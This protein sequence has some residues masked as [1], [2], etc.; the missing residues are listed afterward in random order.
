MT[1]T[2]HRLL[3]ITESL[4]CWYDEN[5]RDLPWRH[6]KEPYHIWISEIMAQQT[7]INFLLAYY[8]R[9]ISRFPTVQSLAEAPQDEVLK[10]W[11]GLGYYSR[12]K[13]LHKAAK[14]IAAEFGGV[15]PDTRE[16]LL[17]LPGVG[18]YTAGAILSIA[19]DKP[20][21][22]V[23][24]NV[25]RVYARLETDDI[26][27]ATPAAKGKAGA[28][29]KQLFPAE[30]AGCLTQAL[31][32]LGALVCIPKTPKCALCPVSEFCLAFAKGNQNLLP[33]KS[34]KKAPKEVQK[35]VLILRDP[36]GRVLMRQRT[37]T[38]LSGLWEYYIVDEKL[39]E[40]QVKIYLDKIDCPAAQLIPMGAAKHVFTHM[41]WHM[42]G[43]D[44]C[45]AGN[46]CPPGYVFISPAERQAL[47]LPAAYRYYTEQI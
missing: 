33:R 14:R 9:F 12:A 23:D 44:C 27:I 18:D 11:E 45:V 41:I 1:N 6:S 5:K 19:Y 40:E 25:L 8:N 21:P 15:L 37:E 13:N 4:L 28:F 22:A 34:A 43:Y 42:T 24:G 35:T 47:P 30:R 32:E 29:V 17:S 46:S 10:V 3:S 2:N 20:E 16:G 38:L 36:K 26:D 39:T 7:R 31:M